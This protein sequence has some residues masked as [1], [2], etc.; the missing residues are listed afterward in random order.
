MS[1]TSAAFSSSNSVCTTWR[2]FLRTSCVCV[3]RY[4]WCESGPHSRNKFREKSQQ[5]ACQKAAGS[6]KRTLHV[7]N[8]SD[9]ASLLAGASRAIPWARRL[10]AA[11]IEDTGGP[12]AGKRGPGADPEGATGERTGRRQTIG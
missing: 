5:N 8:D 7:A 10:C 2:F 6:L 9:C 4:L 3:S 11:A 12:F 1:I